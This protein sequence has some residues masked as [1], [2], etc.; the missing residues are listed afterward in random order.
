MGSENENAN[1]TSD[2]F[3]F[4]S[5]KVYS[6]EEW[7]QNSTKKYRTVY[8]KAETTY[9]SAEFSFY[10]K[11]FD[12]QDWEAN[13][14]LKAYSLGEGDK[15]TELC[16]LENK[17][18][19]KMDENIVVCL[20]GWGNATPGA[21]WTRGDYQWEASIDGEVVGTQNFYVEDIGL[22]TSE[23]N[24]YFTVESLKLYA[25]GFD[26][27]DEANRKYV[28]KFKRD[29]TCY[30]WAEFKYKNIA[31]EGHFVE[32]YMNFYDDA[33]Q[34]KASIIKS[35]YLAADTN[36]QVF[37][38]S[39]GWGSDKA[40]GWKDNKYTVEIVFMDTL[41]AVAPFEVG[42]EFVEGNPEMFSSQ[43]FTP[44]TTAS[45]SATETPETLED[46]LKNLDELIGLASVKQKIKE[47][48]KYIDFLKLRKEKGFKEAEK[49]ALHSVFTGNPGTGK[50]TVVNLLGKIYNKMGM[51]SK[52]HVIEADRADLVAAFIGQTAP[53]VKKLIDDARGGILFIDEAYSLAREGDD[54]KDFGKEVIEILI[55]EMSDGPGDIAIMV[56]GYPKEM[57]HFI[58]SNPGL[59]SRFSY[60]F[61][62]DDY[63]PEEL[64]AIAELTCTKRD[65]KLAEPAKIYLQKVLTEAYRNRDNSFGNARFALSLIDEGKMNLG[66]RL[67]NNANVA[68]LDGD[69]IST[70]ELADVENIVSRQAKKR[71]DLKID[72][73]LLSASLA[74]LKTLTGLPE[75]KQEVS[76]LVKLVRYYR[77]TGKD[78]L[79]KFSLHSVFTGNPGTGKT[80]VARIMGK[81][82]KA[83]GFLERGHVV[84][85]DRERLVAGYI[86]QTAIKTKEMVE[87]A[88]GGVL[89]IDEAY[90]LAEGV[91][92][93]FGKEAIEVI[94]KNME[95]LRGELAVIVAGYPDNMNVFLESNPGLKSRFDKFYHFTDFSVDELFEI[96]SAL[97]AKENLKADAKAEE[98]LKA[99][100]SGMFA[101]KDRYFGNA[102]TVRNIAEES[103]RHQQ[104]RMAGIESSKR[105][106]EM[107]ETLTVD[108]VLEF[109]VVE[110]NTHPSGLGFK[111]PGKPE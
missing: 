53:K 31:T 45:N 56:A 104:L 72:E 50:T 62:F 83:L 36:G 58:D 79:N 91:E 7:M 23:K 21:Y 20:D 73:E 3:K 42:E 107:M 43:V 80:T 10:N 89:F 74:E 99:Y 57:M 90:A 51:L 47:H 65:V 59:K 30:V 14:C 33:G 28:K 12:E 94:L 102:R 86:G 93:D 60:Y 6:S 111:L 13:V 76:D 48:I 84:E 110:Q 97:I 35:E 39:E 34:P 95:D 15:R 18:S 52:G 78:I 17:K 8:D 5:L 101:N 68:E 2:K 16:K 38:V 40:G 96:Y 77:E 44:S 49:I 85:C 25:G 4:K 82:F 81:I 26:R 29:E 71:L 108:D 24:P 92:N 98:H 54:E 75:V 100:L 46:V 106:Q 27:I 55:K 67:M 70:I 1:K 22:V 37:E 66:L 9:L 11:L 87:A 105:T 41:V 103:I 88:K 61:N 109:K 19:I 69:A 64:M 63:L 32:F